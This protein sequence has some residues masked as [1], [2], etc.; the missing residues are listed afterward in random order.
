MDSTSGQPGW[1]LRY[2]IYPIESR[3]EKT[4]QNSENVQLRGVPSGVGSLNRNPVPVHLNPGNPVVSVREI[5]IS[6]LRADDKMNLEKCCGDS[7]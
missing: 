2:L 4:G 6:G 1:L 7:D 3:P 5:N